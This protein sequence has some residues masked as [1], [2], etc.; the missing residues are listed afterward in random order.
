MEYRE[1]HEFKDAW[2]LT[3][4]NEVPEASIDKKEVES[5]KQENV[6]TEVNK[7][8]KDTMKTEVNKEVKDIKEIKE[9]QTVKAPKGPKPDDLSNSLSFHEEPIN[10][11]VEEDQILT[12][13]KG[14]APGDMERG[15]YIITAVFKEKDKAQNY[16]DRLFKSGTNSKVA[17]H[18]GKKYYYIYL[19]QADSEEKA[20]NERLKLK[21]NE[22]LKDTWI[23]KVE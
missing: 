10:I 18:S 7:E 17:Y 8:V 14:N 1:K 11:L 16:S 9:P 12:I 15:Y 22:G 2:L 5:V 20:Q 23:L 19:K 13:Q 3:V 6:K 21:Q 4:E